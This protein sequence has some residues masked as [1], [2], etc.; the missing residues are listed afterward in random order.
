M[1]TKRRTF[2]DYGQKQVT[3]DSKSIGDLFPGYF[4]TAFE[5]T[6]VCTLV[7][8]LIDFFISVD[9]VCATIIKYINGYFILVVQMVFRLQICGD[10]W[11]IF[12]FYLMNP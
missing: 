12:Q 11:K 9:N 3:G 4:G 2:A 5:N 6:Y 7:I 8:I 1:F 10:V